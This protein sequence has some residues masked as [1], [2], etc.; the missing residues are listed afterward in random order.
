MKYLQNKIAPFLP[1]V[2]GINFH[3]WAYAQLLHLQILRRSTSTSISST[4]LR[5]PLTHLIDFFVLKTCPILALYTVS[6][7]EKRNSTNAKAVFIYTQ[8]VGEIDPFCQFY[9]HFTSSF[10]ADFLLPKIINPIGKHVKA[11]KTLVH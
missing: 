10:C 4:C 1:F 11:S 3:Q 2:P 7:K 5:P 8:F 6:Q 9:Q